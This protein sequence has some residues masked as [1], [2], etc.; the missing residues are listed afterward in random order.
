[1]LILKIHQFLIQ[2]MR[3]ATILDSKMIYVQVTHNLSR[4]ET[5]TIVKITS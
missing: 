5:T 4:E 3:L 2:R 1:M